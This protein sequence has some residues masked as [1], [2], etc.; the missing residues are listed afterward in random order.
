MNDYEIL[1]GQSTRAMAARRHKTRVWFVLFMVTAA[2]LILVLV[3]NSKALGI[4]G[5]GF[6]GLLILY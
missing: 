6:L 2:L 5:F 4:G 1:A 3:F